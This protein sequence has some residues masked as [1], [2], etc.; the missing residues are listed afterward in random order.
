MRRNQAQHRPR[1]Y[2]Q[3]STS[4]GLPQSTVQHHARPVYNPRHARPDEVHAIAEENMY[5]DSLCTLCSGSDHR[6]NHHHMSTQGARD[7]A[8]QYQ[9]GYLFNCMMCKIDESIVRPETRKIILTSSTLYNVWKKK[10]LKLPIHVEMES[11]V[12]GRIRDM[13]RAL[14][15][16]YLRYPERLEIILIAGLNNVGEGQSAEEILEEIKELKDAVQAHSE[17]HGHAEPSIV[18]ISTYNVCPKVLFSG[19]TRLHP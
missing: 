11:I 12:G 7:F 18:S 14:I 4:R 19:R 17:I 1:P 8:S 5:G 6:V 15:M 13:T 16:L 3:P 9:R 2:H 10:E